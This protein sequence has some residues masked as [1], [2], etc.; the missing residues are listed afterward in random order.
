MKRLKEYMTSG[1]AARKW[2]CSRSYVNLLI[3]QKRLTGTVWVGIK[4][5]PIYLIPAAMK[6]SDAK[7]LTTAK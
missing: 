2:K 6:L 1:E 4:E 5:K 7:G 3:S